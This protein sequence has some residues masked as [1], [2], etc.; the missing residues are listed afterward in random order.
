[1]ALFT[2][3]SNKAEVDHDEYGPVPDDES[4]PLNDVGLETELQQREIYALQRSLRR[5]NLFLKIIIGLLAVTIIALLSINVP[6]TVKKIKELPTLATQNTIVKN[7]V[8]VCT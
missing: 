3:G 2:S 4:R 6:D 5:T 7:P 8:G 1:M